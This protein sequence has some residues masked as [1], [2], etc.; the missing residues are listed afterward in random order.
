MRSVILVLI[1]GIA[2]VFCFTYPWV[3]ALLYMWISVMNPHKL[4]YGIGMHIPFAMI[5]AIVSLVALAITKQRRGIPHH[6]LVYLLV[7]LVAW[8]C[9]TSLNSTNVKKE[10]MDQLIVV[11]KTQLMVFVLIALV[12]ERQAM[13]YMMM[14]LVGSIA[15]F[16]LKGGVW[17]ILT[18]GSSLVWGPPS[19]AI[20][21]NNE[22]GLALVTILP[23][24][25]FIYEMMP[26]FWMRMVVAFIGLMCMFS[27]LGTHSRGALLALVAMACFLGLKSKRPIL[28]TGFLALAIVAGLIFMPDKWAD[29]MDT[30]RNYQGDGSA[31]S[32]LHTWSVI[33]RSALDNPIFGSGFRLDNF[34][35]YAKYSTNAVITTTYGPHSIY[36]QA[37]GEHG[38]VGLILFVSL[39]A[40]TW[41]TLGNL[42][43][44]FKAVEGE[45]WAALLCKMMQAG[46][47]GF[48]AGG[49]FL[50]LMHWDIPYYLIALVI[51]LHRYSLGLA[52]VE[53]TRHRDAPIG[54]R[55]SRG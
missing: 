6:P 38:F 4:T 54:M 35:F 53:Q 42:A 31:L 5:A 39:L 36:F 15:F 12:F 28:F 27:V 41:F 2:L 23:L 55:Y 44:R 24:L 46:L 32:R 19:S 11:L 45:A 52:P 29:R 8:M 16:G 43:K 26:K 22:L 34:D 21:G 51:I 20:E 13:I 50:G 1:F 40:T 3:G 9:L 47:I 48:C 18:G 30:I 7:A 25:Y 17:T 49:A 14:V 33:W 10:V 37:L